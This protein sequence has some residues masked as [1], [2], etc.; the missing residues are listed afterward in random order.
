M[1]ASASPFLGLAPFLRLNING[2][3]L[4]PL[5]QQLLPKAEALPEDANL[6]MNLSTIM[7]CVGLHELGLATQAQAL[8]LQ[9][10]YREPAAQQ[11]ARLRVLLLMAPGDLAANTPLDCLLEDSDVDLIWY[12]V[13]AAAEPFPE[14]IPEHDLAMVAMSELDENH[15]RLGALSLRLK[16]WPKP[17]VNRPEAIGNTDRERASTLLQGVPGLLIPP[18]FPARRGVL[19]A[20][21][22]RQLPLSELFAGCDFPVILRPLGSHAGHDLERLEHAEAL[23]DYLARVAGEWFFISRFIDYSGADGMFRKYRVALI[24]GQ[25]Y[26]SH[27]GVSAHWMIHYLNAGMY[28]DAAKRAQEGAWMEDFAAF[29]ARHRG[30]LAAIHQRSG[31]DYLC[32]DC[33]ETREGELLVFEIDHAM[34]VHA[35]DPAE[36][37]PY[38]QVHMAKAKAAMRAYLLRRAGLP[39]EASGSAA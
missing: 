14:P 16:D 32:V 21:A 38:K 22:G 15:T 36:L 30:A 35:M 2:T 27:M 10:V 12:Y 37:F 5:L 6:W 23:A 26:A 33:A 13:S 8:A 29:A 3:D 31:L 19:D 11:P 20:V 18:T 28:E 34:V 17:V 9:R 24:D 4:R 39:A 25:P 7:L 1:S